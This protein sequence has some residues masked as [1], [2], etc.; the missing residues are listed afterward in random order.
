MEKNSLKKNVGKNLLK[1][2]TERI[3]FMEM[4]F[5]YIARVEEK[6]I[7]ESVRQENHGSFIEITFHSYNFS[8]VL[9]HSHYLSIKFGRSKRVGT[10]LPTQYT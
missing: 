4:I 5:M 9:I 2:V 1:S 8:K 10:Y 3:N 7:T 6:K